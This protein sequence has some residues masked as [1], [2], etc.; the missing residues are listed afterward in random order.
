MVIRPYT[1]F[2]QPGIE[3]GLTY[4]DDPGVNIPSAVTAWVA[5]SGIYCISTETH[6][7]RLVQIFTSALS[8]QFH[9]TAKLFNSYETRVKELSELQTHERNC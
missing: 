8:L 4:F 2:H 3:F 6:P 1:E 5:M 9:R 7:Y